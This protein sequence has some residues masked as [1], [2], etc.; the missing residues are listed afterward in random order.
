MADMLLY[1]KLVM[2]GFS[3]QVGD[4]VPRP[5][6]QISKYLRD[7]IFEQ[8]DS[9]EA[10]DITPVAASWFMQ[11]EDVS[12]PAG[13]TPP[14]QNTW[15][16]YAYPPQHRVEGRVR[17]L[18]SGR[19][20]ALLTTIDARSKDGKTL[21][22][23]HSSI[24]SSTPEL[25]DEI[26]QEL[27]D[28]MDSC[29]RKN[30]DLSSTRWVVCYFGFIWPGSVNHV[31]AMTHTDFQFLNSD[32]NEIVAGAYPSPILMAAVNSGQIG[33]DPVGADA[34]KITQL[35]VSMREN[36]APIHIALELMNCKN[37]SLETRDAS[38][39]RRRR[40]ERRSKPTKSFHVLVV[41]PPGNTKSG[42]P[43]QPMQIGSTPLHKVRGHFKTYSQDRP[44]FGQYHG[45][46]WFAP[47][48]RGKEEHGEVIKTY[49]VDPG[50]E[51]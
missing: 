8:L 51:R 19:C 3:F 9:A 12:F 27:P 13:M 37:I 40:L 23:L 20:G 15:V 18:G 6:A 22:S 36:M 1:D 41:T 45:K 28:Y 5:D 32:G 4:L 29:K 43:R 39:H 25:P 17:K 2:D 50:G 33:A 24:R 30:V 44:L 46:F 42:A 26:V 7:S 21:V 14:Y 10:V 38:H 34:I 47:H 11:K 35:G 31:T 16:E 49:E 48:A